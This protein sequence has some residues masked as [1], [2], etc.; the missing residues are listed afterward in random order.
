MTSVPDN[1]VSK[2]SRLTRGRILGI[3]VVPFVN[4]DE[5]NNW[6]NNAKINP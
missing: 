5:S 4:V 2:M 6:M 1:D 3:A